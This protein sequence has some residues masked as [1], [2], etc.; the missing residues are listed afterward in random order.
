LGTSISVVVGQVVLQNEV[1]KR[2]GQLV[3]ALGP[4]LA[5]VIGGGNAGANAKTISALPIAQRNV[6]HNVLTDS[7]RYVW[8]VYTCFSALGLILGL[9]I[10]KQTLNKQHE[11]TKTGLAAE[12]EN[13]KRVIAER[14]A[15]KKA[16]QIDVELAASK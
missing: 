1:A 9:F 12:E 16:K 6:V 14:E 3:A 15:G 8:V 4:Q 11:E 13:R 2:Q 10:T 5:A 7:L